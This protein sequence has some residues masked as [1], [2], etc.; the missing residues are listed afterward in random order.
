MSYTHLTQE[1]RYCIY[2]MRMAGWSAAR[3]GRTLGRP[4]CTITR[5]V[6]RNTSPYWDH[7]L[8]DYA[9]RKAVERRQAAC[10]RR[11]T[12]DAE[13]MAYVQRKIEGR[14][15][16]EQIAGRLAAA[17]PESLV[18][19]TISHTTIYRWLW[20]CPHRSQRLKQ[21]RITPR[22]WYRQRAEKRPFHD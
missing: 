13:L 1:D 17:A 10:R 22:R 18:G 16:P 2:H 21:N 8:D 3:I 15:S 6:K 9:Q 19:K 12:D 5:E 4:R 14:W 7:Y 11:C 20:A